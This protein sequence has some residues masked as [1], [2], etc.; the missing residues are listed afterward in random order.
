[1]YRCLKGGCEGRGKKLFPVVC[2]DRTRG[3]GDK[4]KHVGEVPPQPQ[5]IFLHC[6]GDQAVAQVSQKAAGDSQSCLEV[7][8]DNMLCMSLPDH[9]TK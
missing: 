5:E 2:S 6:E 8:L 1:M 9:L 7:V 3:T 4:L